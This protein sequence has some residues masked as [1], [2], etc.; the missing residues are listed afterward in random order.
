MRIKITDMHFADGYYDVRRF[1]IGKTGE[2]YISMAK[3]GW[4][5]GVVHFDKPLEF[6]IGR[7]S[8]KRRDIVVYRIKYINLDNKPAR[9]LG[10]WGL[11]WLAWKTQ[12]KIWLNWFTH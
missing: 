1:L 4:A 6:K 10:F 7:H 12:I 8:I 5:G 11:T 3:D 9:R 2:F